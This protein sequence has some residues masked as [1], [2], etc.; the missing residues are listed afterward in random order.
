MNKKQKR[1]QLPKP[2]RTHILSEINE[3]TK[4]GFCSKC[5]EK[6]RIRKRTPN[7]LWACAIIRRNPKPYVDRIGHVVVDVDLENLQGWC[8]TCNCLVK[9]KPSK[10]GSLNCS[11]KMKVGSSA[12]LAEKLILLQKYIFTISKRRT[13]HIT[14]E[15]YRQYL[16]QKLLERVQNQS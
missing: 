12:T 8:F 7:S 1:Y 11:G 4:I 13:T 5:Q 6:V 16:E 15:Q 3:V 14:L 9:L 2:T 10:S